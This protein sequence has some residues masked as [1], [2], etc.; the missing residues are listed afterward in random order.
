MILSV[1][2]V[3]KYEYKGIK[4]VCVYGGGSVKDQTKI[5]TAGVEIIIAT[6]GRFNDLVSR[7]TICLDSITYVVLDEADR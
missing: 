4:S 7:G 3:A 2:K 1:L 6:P 5:I